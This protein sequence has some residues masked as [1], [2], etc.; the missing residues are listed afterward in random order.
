VNFGFQSEFGNEWLKLG[1]IKLFIDGGITGPKASLYRPYPHDVYDFGLL[2]HSQKD[3]TQ[4]Y[5]KAHTAGLQII[6]HTTGEKA[7]DMVMN[8][9]EAALHELPNTDHRHRLEHAGN[10]FATPDRMQRMLELGAI[11]AVNPQFIHAFGFLMEHFYGK[12]VKN[13]LFPFRMLLDMG[14]KLPFSSDSTG[15]QPEGTN[16]FWGIWCAVK[17]ES[18]DGSIIDSEQRISVMEAIRCHT[19]YS[20]YAGFEEKIKGSIES[21]KLADLIVVSDDPLTVSVDKIKDIKV[22]MTIIGGKIRY[23]STD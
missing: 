15:T 22:K 11:P 13:G 16:P 12:R 21:G 23:N 8:S 3:L 18:F 17:R 19:I 9:I 6:S 7:Q 4:I 1:G 20:A 2:N 5:V 14:F 10:Y